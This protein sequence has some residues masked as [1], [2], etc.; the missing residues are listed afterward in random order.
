MQEEINQLC[1]EIK[2]ENDK[3][4]KSAL[5]MQKMLGMDN[6]IITPHI[7]YN[8]QESIDTLLEATFNNIR[9]FSKGMHN[10]QVC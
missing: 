10:N 4:I 9:D 6:V 3:C 8:T 1:D 7:A 2:R 5:V